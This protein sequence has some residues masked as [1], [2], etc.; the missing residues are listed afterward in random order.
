MCGE[1][2]S[3]T[4]ESLGSASSAWSAPG[5]STGILSMVRAVAEPLL[6]AAAGNLVEAATVPAGRAGSPKGREVDGVPLVEPQH[7]SLE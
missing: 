3:I 1:I 4:D 6:A 2:Q 7:C 5:A